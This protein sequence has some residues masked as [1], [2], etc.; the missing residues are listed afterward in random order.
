MKRVII[1]GAAGRDFHNFNTYF[2]HN[3][4]YTVVAF[5]AAQIP[6]IE[7]RKYPAELAGRKYP[8]GIPIY[9]EK[10]LEKLI[11]EYEVNICVFSY[12]DVPYKRVMEVSARVN[13]AG[14]S[15][16]LLGPND[17]M[18]K[19]S[20]PVISVC[21]TR[22][23]CGKSQTSRKI[24]EIL[25]NE[26]LKVVAIRHP[27]PYGDLVKQKV[28]RFA[29]IE[30]LKFHKC[31]IEEME[32]YEPHIVRGNV[33]YAGVD[34]EAIL[35]AAEND[36]DGCDIIL[37]DGGN[38]D[39]SFYQPDLSITVVDPY[40]VNHELSYYPGEVNLRMADI[41]IINKIDS[42]SPE[43]VN[44]LRSNIEKTN[45]KAIVID[46][47]S[48][49]RVDDITAIKGKKVLVV[50]DGPT[51]THGEMK[52][53]AGIVAAKKYGA[54]E[55]VDPRPFVVGKLAETY[56]IYPNIGPLLPAMGYGDEQVKDLQATIDAV[57][58]DSVIIGTPID[59]NRVVKINKPNTRVHYDL[60]EIGFPTLK[61]QLKEFIK[62]HHLT[63]VKL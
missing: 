7:G 55:I 46:G 62:N 29:T 40:R 47:A 25:M 43:D 27:M 5:T 11:V 15:F 30:D 41:I 52:L 23:G 17:T 18:I 50:E 60:Q 3:N 21:A 19:S 59:L 36:P 34:Y 51:L 53:G 38:N 44:Q 58:C 28:Q 13:S 12:S 1:I 33:I 14:A 63:G 56:K 24:I 10:D 48:P 42:A 37:W 57:P 39:F 54:A 8:D 6:D 49:I 31:T 20:K 4:E 9:A 22:T 35:R 2:R 61:D 45:P 16:M 32:E 26:G